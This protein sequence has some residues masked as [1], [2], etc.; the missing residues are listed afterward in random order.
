M[1]GRSGPVDSGLLLFFVA[2]GSICH[3]TSF[4]SFGLMAAVGCN[5]AGA[6]GVQGCMEGR[7]E[8]GQWS[9]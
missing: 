3:L 6:K 9:G 7:M 2:I 1:G 8:E 5:A 4:G